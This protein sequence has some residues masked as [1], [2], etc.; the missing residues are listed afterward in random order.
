[1]FVVDLIRDTH[2]SATQHNNTITAD[3]TWSPDIYSGYTALLSS[4]M[5]SF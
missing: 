2:M 1:M 5:H 4:P 3:M